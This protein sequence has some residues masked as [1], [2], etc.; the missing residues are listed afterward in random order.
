MSDD[1]RQRPYRSNESIARTGEARGTVSSG[2]DPLAELARLIGQTDPFGDAMK[3][4]SRMA[5]STGTPQAA[6]WISPAA[7]PQTTPSYASNEFTFPPIETERTAPAQASGSHAYAQSHPSDLYQ[8][9]HDIPAYLTARGPGAAGGPPAY[10]QASPPFGAGHED[11]YDDLPPPRRRIGVIAIAAIFGLAVVGTA[12]AFGYRSLFGGS[13]ARVPP[14]ITADKAPLKVVPKDASADKKAIADRVS[15]PSE[16]VV[17]REEKPVDISQK[18]V[19]AGPDVPVGPAAQ[20]GPAP[21]MSMPAARGTG[22]LSSEPKRVQT[23]VIR[24]DGSEAQYPMASPMPPAAAMPPTQPT[25]SR[26]SAPA[27]MASA[28]PHPAARAQAAAPLSLNP[29]AEPAP[30]RPVRTASAAP[31]AVSAPTSA[32]H[33]GYAVQVSS[34]RSEAEAKAAFHSLQGKYPGQLGGKS[35]FVHKV[36]LGAKGVYYR[37]M[38]GPFASASEAGDLCSGLKSAGGSCFVQRN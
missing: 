18:I 37:T 4:S 23:I 10:S 17:P 5:E 35:M 24:P 27:P 25:A 29:N 16:K 34:Q 11:L 33:G 12:G 26:P 13:G 8:V 2:S 30:A 21:S 1:Y 36:D 14:V 20:A 3:T 22:V 9:E 28:P 15:D 6:E 31:T 19:S 38:V 7:Q 32:S